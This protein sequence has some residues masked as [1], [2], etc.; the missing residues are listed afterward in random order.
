M[1]LDRLF[2]TNRFLFSLFRSVELSHIIHA[3]DDFSTCVANVQKS[4]TESVIFSLSCQSA[5]HTDKLRI[6]CALVSFL[7]K[8]CDS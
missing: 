3:T 2:Q 7:R 4:L 6:K 5:S 1:F 8:K